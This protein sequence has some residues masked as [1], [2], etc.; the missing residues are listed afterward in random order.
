MARPKRNLGE[1]NALERIEDAFWEMLSNGSYSKITIS[2]LAQHSKVNHNTIYYHFENID[3]MAIKLFN[4]NLDKDF[5]TRVFSSFTTNGSISSDLSSD[6]EFRNRFARIQLFA[7]SDSIFLTSRF[8]QF[9][10]EAWLIAFNIPQKNLSTENKLFLE[11]FFS[12]L[13]AVIG[14]PLVA[15]NPNMLATVLNNNIVKELLSYLTDLSKKTTSYSR[16]E[17]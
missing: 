15:E 17:L 10:L 12:G 9:I 4:K 14:N 3:D 7:Q 5:P 11:F 16:K 13:T 6:V 8:K 2:S 1:K